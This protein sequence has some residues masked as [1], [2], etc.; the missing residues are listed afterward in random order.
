[1]KKQYILILVICLAVV[2]LLLYKNQTN[3]TPTSSSEEPAK[4]ENGWY[5]YNN[6]SLGF[7]INYPSN[8]FK[9]SDDNQESPA[10]YFSNQNVG[11]PLEM[12]PGG[13][14]VEVSKNPDTY[15]SFDI[16]LESYRT[17][18][19]VSGLT[20][21]TNTTE[22]TLSDQEAYKYIAKTKTDADTEQIYTVNYS[23][24]QGDH[25]YT[26]MFMTLDK[27]TA[28][29]NITLYDEFAASFKLMQ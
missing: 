9:V 15:K 7:S 4:A 1:M 19:A 26:L 20:E 23:L 18:K 3:N 28:D 10:V 12:T 21:Y 14:Y 27:A 24:K 8:W 29:Q 11:A 6:T 22:I 13:V 25:V 5:K 16:I 2:A 17:G